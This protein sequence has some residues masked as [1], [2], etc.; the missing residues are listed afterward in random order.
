M[1][2]SFEE[3]NAYFVKKLNI[4]TDTYLDLQGTEHDYFFAVAGANRNEV[5]LGLRKAIDDAILRGATLE[6]FR[7]SF[8]DIVTSTG[9]NFNGGRNWR[10]RIIYDTNIYGSYNR[11]RLQQH[12]EMAEEMPFWEYIH[13]DARHPRPQH[14]AWNGLVL[15]YD[16]PFWKY[17]YPIKAY[18]CHCTVVAHDEDN[19]KRFNKK[20]GKSPAIEWVEK[21]VGQRSG[22]P[23]IVNIPKGYDVGFAPNDFTHLTATRDANIDMVLLQKMI[24]APPAFAARAVKSLFEQSTIMKL[25]MNSHKKWVDALAS[26]DKEL[27]KQASNQRLVGVINQ[28]TLAKLDEL[29]LMPQ[30]AVIAMEKG[31]M[32]HA[33][34]DSKKMKGLD[35]PIEFWQKLPEKLQNPDAILLQK[36]SDQRNKNALNVLLFIYNTEQGKVAVKLNYAIAIKSLDGK[37]NTVQVNLART[38]S[39]LKLDDKRTKSS[40]KG[41]ELLYGKID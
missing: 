24:S 36:A 38:G 25:F 1:P 19:L 16:D 8:D 20:V 12:L 6:D 30:S 17:H 23:Q 13:N 22:I 7:K 14:Q 26:S 34:R 10:T 9:W 21:E 41:F 32:M 2:L 40:L 28:Q 29:G 5:L 35:L 31:D 18:G 15:R 3:Q 27:L 39:E 33:I 37:K 11:G 4:P